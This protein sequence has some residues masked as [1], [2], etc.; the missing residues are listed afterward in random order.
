MK[1]LTIWQPWASLIMLGAKPYEFRRWDYRVRNRGLEGQRIVIHAGARPVKLIEIEDII[2]RVDDGLSSLLKEK[3][4][5]L[6]DRIKNAYKGRGV[7]ELSAGLGTATLG[8]PISVSNLFHA[9]PVFTH[10]YQ[11]RRV[12]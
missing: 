2:D 8:E 10:S 3:A 7:V 6:L 1:A 4:M 9:Y 12:T 5:P 11:K